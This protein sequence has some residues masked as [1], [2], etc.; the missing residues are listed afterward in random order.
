MRLRRAAAILLI[1]ATS[2]WC[3]GA[4][5]QT[6]K[7]RPA[8]AMA[9]R[10]DLELNDRGADVRILQERLRALGYFQ[11]PVTGFFGPLTLK[12]VKEFQANRGLPSTGYV[13]P[14][15]RRAL[16]AGNTDPAVSTRVKAGPGKSKPPAPAKKDM[17]PASAVVSPQTPDPTP[18]PESSNPP[19]SSTGTGAFA[20]SRSAVAG[21]GPHLALTFDDGPDP[22][23]LPG[24]LKAL[25][26]RGV[27][28]TF[29]VVGKDAA[30]HPNLVRA[31]AAAG[32]EIE[33]HGYSHRD[34]TQ[35]SAGEKRD[36]IT[37]TARLIK[38]LTGRE[39]RFFRPPLGAYDTATFRVANAAGH[40]VVLWTNIGAADVPPP[41]TAKL[42]R[43]VSAA[44]HE[45]AVIMLHANR[46][47]TAEALPAVLDALMGRGFRLVTLQVLLRPRP[48]P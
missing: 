42:V 48:E 32:H 46:P 39:T 22:A 6:A 5:A 37:R 35:L 34:F 24:I 21:T 40:R 9:P 2:L 44:A 36:E 45:G 10:G 27:R 18:S 19:A 3:Q 14:L 41:G 28:A 13:G 15:T 11:G 16:A 47:E 38:D 30:A 17:Q 1:I 26:D 29:F 25:G 7:P 31:M 20:G 23:V 4:L 8:S 43:R 33:N 12:A